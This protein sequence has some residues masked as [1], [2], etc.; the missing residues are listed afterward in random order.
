[1]HDAEF[2][3]HFRMNRDTFNKLSALLYVPVKATGRK[4]VPKDK[5]LA[6]FLYRMAT[7]ETCR[8]LGVVF[9]VSDSTVVRATE[10]ITKAIVVA[11]ATRIRFPSTPEVPHI[12]SA[13]YKRRVEA[14]YRAIPGAFA[15]IDGTY[16]KIPKP[17]GDPVSFFNRK[18][19]YSINMQAVVIHDLR[20]IDVH[21]GA[22][23]STHDAR[24]FRQSDFS[25]NAPRL[26]PRG[27]YVLADSG[28]SDAVPYILTPFDQHNNRNHAEKRFNS[29]LSSTRV[30]VERAFGLLKG[31]W[32]RLT[33]MNLELQ[34]IPKTVLAMC[35]VHN[36]LI[37]ESDGWEDAYADIANDRIRHRTAVH[38]HEQSIA[39]RNR[40][41]NDLMA[42]D[43]NDSSNSDADDVEDSDE[44]A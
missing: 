37:E 4:G 32:A 23:G 2:K 38:P 1:M 35:M 30:M 44:D 42:V 22:P 28:Y 10:V 18:S 20:F 36:F 41:M 25:V 26:I 17:R 8:E 40:I 12:A 14:G 33:K 29:V 43:G 11:L 21:I 6:I 31:R 15:A 5:L 13:L 3:R 24:M 34:M 39:A 9:G 7:L 16:I 27:Y 19:Y